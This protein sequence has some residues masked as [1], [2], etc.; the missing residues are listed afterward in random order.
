MSVV[1]GEVGWLFSALPSSQVSSS[2]L[3]ARSS[4]SFVFCKIKAQQRKSSSGELEL[5]CFFLPVRWE[6]WGVGCCNS[7]LARRAGQLER[8]LK[9]QSCH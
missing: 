6:V 8:Y 9:H 3:T 5:S 7:P 1:D 4:V 2:Q